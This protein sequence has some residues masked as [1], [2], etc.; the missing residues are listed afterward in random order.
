M[1]VTDVPDF[2]VLGP[3]TVTPSA[4]GEIVTVADADAVFAFASVAMTDIV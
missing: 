4:M 3:V 1:N 2:A